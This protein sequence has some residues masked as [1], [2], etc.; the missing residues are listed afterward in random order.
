MKSHLNLNEDWN[1]SDFLTASAHSRS[2]VYCI[3]ISGPHHNPLFIKF[4]PLTIDGAEVAKFGTRATWWYNLVLIRHL[5]VL[6]FLIKGFGN[7]VVA[8][9]VVLSRKTASYFT[10]SLVKY[11]TSLQAVFVFTGTSGNVFKGFSTKW[12]TIKGHS[13]TTWTIF[14]PILTLSYPLPI[15]DIW[16]GSINFVNSWLLLCQPL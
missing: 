7:N 2:Y 5:D 12:S 14:Y 16:Q 6:T 8:H 1:I 10:W 11:K 9:Y 13:T 3:S 15:V 4:V